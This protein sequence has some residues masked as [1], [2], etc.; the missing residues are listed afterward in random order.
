MRNIKYL[1]IIIL[2]AIAFYGCQKNTFNVSQRSTPSGVALVKIGFF[3]ATTLAN[4][5]IGYINGERSTNALAQP[6]TF[7]GGGL[8][9][10]G[11]FNADYLQ[12]TPGPVTFDFYIP[13]TGTAISA[14]KYFS[15]TKTFE[16]NKKYTLL[17]TDTAANTT[18]FVTNDDAPTPDTMMAKLKF[19]NAIPGSNSVD[20]YKGPTLASAVLLKSD[21]KYLSTTDYITIPSGTDSFF[22]QLSGNNPAVSL[23]I[24]RRGFALG[25]QRIYTMLGRGYIPISS[26][27]RAINLSVIVNQ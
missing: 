23:P 14:V 1:G 16:S 25:S 3:S 12:V 10:N 11:S 26:G 24:V 9:M 5:V 17:I 4:P 15:T 27:S 8:N 22:V 20:L 7:P 2:I 19:A 18:A 21:I 13:V 6:T